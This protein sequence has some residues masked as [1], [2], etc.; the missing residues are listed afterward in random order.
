[1]VRAQIKDEDGGPLQRACLR[2][3]PPHTPLSTHEILEQDN[4]KSSCSPALMVHF[5]VCHF[6]PFERLF[7]TMDLDTDYYSSP[8]SKDINGLLSV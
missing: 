2:S 8:T 5:A 4:A 1:M 6:N 3:F 7:S